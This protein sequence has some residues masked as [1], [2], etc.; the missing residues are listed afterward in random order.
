MSKT[1]SLCK[2]TMKHLLKICLSMLVLILC[3][4]PSMSPRHR[5]LAVIAQQTTPTSALSATGYAAYIDEVDGTFVYPD[6]QFITNSATDYTMSLWIKAPSMTKPRPGIV[7]SITD[8]AGDHSIDIRLNA[9]ETIAYATYE[10]G[11]GSLTSTRT[12]ADNSW[13]HIVAT[14]SDTLGSLYID[15]TLECTGAVRAV[16]GL[17]SHRYVGC[18]YQTGQGYFWTYKGAIDDFAVWDRCLSSNEQY[19]IYNNGSPNYS[20]TNT[21]A[22]ASGLVLLMRFDENTST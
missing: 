5:K 8:S 4:A 12:V 14:K 6:I 2:Y 20:Q 13:H 7:L 18:M 21:G 15:G 17:V 10:G 16:T 9:A 1:L 19:T 3:M 22:F 11:Y